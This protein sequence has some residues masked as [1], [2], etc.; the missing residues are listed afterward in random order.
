M[1]TAATTLQTRRLIDILRRS[2][3]F[4][5]KNGVESARLDAEVL[6]ANV[7]DMDRIQLYVQ[8]DRPLIR[9]ELERYRDALKRR[10]RRM[11]VAYVTGRKEFM[12]LDFV[13][14]ERVLIPRPDTEVL[15]EAVCSRLAALAI[16]DPIVVDMGAGS[17]AIA[18]AISREVPG[19]RVLATDISGDA[20]EVTASNVARLGLS[21]RV[22]L[23]QGDLFQPTVGTEFEH[24]D[25]LVSNPP[26][27]PSRDIP[28]LAPEI[29]RYEPRLALDGG[30][31]GLDFYRRIAEGVSGRLTGRGFV[32]LEVGD[33]QAAQVTEMLEQVGLI[34][35]ETT[36][37]Y[38]G[39]IR[40]VVGSKPGARGDADVL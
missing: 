9:D 19:A 14:D 17:G 23:A 15:V 21:G 2:T 38:S 34:D 32:A 27:V 6:L 22:F 40:A 26:Y 10:A 11:P 12:S 1:N 16:D 13:V 24:M 39:A 8:H 18:C 28:S 20:L 36:R 37:D 31:D 5:T 30:P 33:G 7:L 25:V 4:L 3:A 35:V 29:S